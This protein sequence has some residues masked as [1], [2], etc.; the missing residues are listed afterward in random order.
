MYRYN[1][2]IPN[3]YDIESLFQTSLVKQ[4]RDKSGAHR[5]GT[6]PVPYT[7]QN[8]TFLSRDQLELGKLSDIR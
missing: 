4:E 3:Y 8:D 5:I 2:A 1:L 7:A 6:D